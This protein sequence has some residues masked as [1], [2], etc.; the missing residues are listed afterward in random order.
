MKTKPQFLFDSGVFQE[1]KL[2]DDKTAIVNYYTDHGFPD[3]KVDKVTR[4]MQTQ[5]GRNY[6]I[7]TVYLTE[8]DQWTYGGMSFSGNQIFSSARLSELVYQKPGKVLSVPEGGAGCLQDSEPV[9]GERLHLQCLQPD[10]RPGTRR[11]R[12]SPT[13]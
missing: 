6:L 3:A 8:G 4:N 13:R 10:A 9:L 7:L 5:Q 1:S 11:P 2:E 12:P